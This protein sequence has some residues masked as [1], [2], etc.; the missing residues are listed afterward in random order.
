MVARWGAWVVFSSGVH[1]S[2]SQCG[3]VPSDLQVDSG[4]LKQNAAPRPRAD[5]TGTDLLRR[6]LAALARPRPP[7]PGPTGPAAGRRP[8]TGSHDAGRRRRPASKAG[9]GNRGRPGTRPAVLVTRTMTIDSLALSHWHPE[10]ARRR[11]VA[12]APASRPTRCL[13]QCAALTAHR[14]AQ[15]T[16]NRPAVVAV[17]PSRCHGTASEHRDWRQGPRP[18][19]GD[20]GG[21]ALTQLDGRPGLAWAPAPAPQ[22]R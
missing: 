16:E 2:L 14:R 9:P 6:S 17:R 13:W 8:R 7:L 21:V 1:S 3:Q 18:G 15:A 4:R 20:P 5:G 12:P 19:G 11:R 22:S 10:S